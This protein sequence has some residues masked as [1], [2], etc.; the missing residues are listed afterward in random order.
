MIIKDSFVSLSFYAVI[1][2]KYVLISYD[3][4]LA[5]TLSQVLIDIEFQFWRLGVSCFW[6]NKSTATSYIVE[7]RILEQYH[8]GTFERIHDGFQPISFESQCLCG[9]LKLALSCKYI[10]N[11]SC[12]TEDIP[13]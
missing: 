7:Q 13:S 4:N 12:G 3:G 11:I 1:V 9:L 6:V 8:K 5:E 2:Q 10:Y